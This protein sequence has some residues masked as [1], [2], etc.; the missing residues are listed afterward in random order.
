VIPVDGAVVGVA[1]H[2]LAGS[3]VD[4]PPGPLD[5][6]SWAHLVD[7]CR[8][9]QLVGM[10]AATAASGDLAVTAGQDEELAVLEAES[11]GLSLL[12]EQRVLT[13]CSLLEAA[14]VDGR[15]LDGPACHRLAYSGSSLRT[16]DRAELLVPPNRLEA[17]LRPPAAGGGPTP[18]GVAVRRRRVGFRAS[19]LPDGWA[20]AAV[21]LGELSEGATI[22]VA[23]RAIRALT[24]EEQLVVACVELAIDSFSDRWLLRARD[25]AELA[26]CA[27]LEAGLVRRLAERWQVTEVAAEM[28]SLVWQVFD[29][30]DKTELSVWALRLDGARSDPAARRRRPPDR[31]P[32]RTASATRVTGWSPEPAGTPIP[33][34]RYQ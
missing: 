29:L 23:G 22:D 21:G 5:D 31:T 10:L 33:T 34:R 16:F 6:E 25:V 30:A 19:A 28:I 32:V 4:V 24:I 13:M 3:R 1:A 18:T 26:L 20:G 11:A 17:M 27:D 2:G 15:L 8:G 14:G 7:A 9:A 12:V